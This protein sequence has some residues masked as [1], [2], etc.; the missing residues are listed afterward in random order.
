MANALAVETLWAICTSR[1]TIAV[2]ASATMSTQGAVGTDRLGSPAGRAPTIATPCFAAR[3]TTAASAMDPTTAI[4]GPGRRGATLPRPRMVT[5][6]A[7][8][9]P[10][11]HRLV[12]GMLRTV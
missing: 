1:T 5:M 2:G 4:S 11:S 12:S 8:D 9:T 7:A 6:T 3:S 10:R